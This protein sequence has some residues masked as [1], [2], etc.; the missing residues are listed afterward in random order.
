MGQ[1]LVN[2]ISLGAAY[3]VLALSFWVIFAVTRTFHLAHVIVLNVAAYTLYWVLIEQ[4]L[5]L[6]PAVLA[7]AVVAMA[8]G[9]VIETVV[10]QPIRR[11][12][13][14]QLIIFVAATAVLAIGQAVLALI[15]QESARGLEE[16][17]PPPLLRVGEIVITRYDGLNVLFA[18]LCGIG[19][20]VVMNR[21]RWG[22][23]MRAVQGNPELAGYFGIPV[24]R[25][26]RI[27]FALG[28]L[29]LIPVVVTLALRSG[30]SP[31]LGFNP[32]LIA[33]I[34]VIAGG[35]E[36]QVGAMAM[37]FLIGLVQ[38][39]VLLELSAQWQPIITFGALF[40]LLLIKPSGLKAAV[41]TRVG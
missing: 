32:V 23:A 16:S 11:H 21:L 3:A 8:L 17:V 41:Q 34:A 28:S 36:S 1:I 4:D 37:A 27:S 6:A 14:D 20:W 26:Y 31:N 35:T 7:A 25:V 38:N 19:V 22:R 12:G 15:F 13:G 39:L 9:V 33:I 5:G 24:Q 10:Y 2:G 18:L 40:L 30:V 29:L